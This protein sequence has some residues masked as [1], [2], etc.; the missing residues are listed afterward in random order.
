YDM[1]RLWIAS[2]AGLP[3]EGQMIDFQLDDRDVS[4]TGCYHHQ[5]F[6][7]R[8]SGYE[9]NRVKTWC[10]TEDDTQRAD[11]ECSDLAGAGGMMSATPACGCAQRRSG[12]LPG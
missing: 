11:E 3:R 2:S 12:W 4:L 1:K 10:S 6:R 7:S 8:W 9:V 5:T